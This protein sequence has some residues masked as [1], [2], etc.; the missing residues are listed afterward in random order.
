V[1]HGHD[2]GGYRRGVV[3][4]VGNARFWV[5][6]DGDGPAILFLHFGLGDW[7]VFEPQLRALAGSF[8]CVAYDR[9]GH[10][11]TESPEEPYAD[12]DDAVGLL[13]AL[14]IERAALV[15]LSG[16]GSIAL[17]IAASHPDRVW[18]LVHIAAPVAGIPWGLSPEHEAA[19]E[20]ADTPEAEEA[21]DY[22]VWAPLGVEDHF[23]E[24]RSQVR[25][26]GADRAPRPP[27]AL[28]EVEAPTLVIT[29]RLDPP[30][31]QASG[32][33]A[34][35]RIPTAQLVEVDSDHYLTLREPERV[36]KLIRDFLAPLA[37]QQ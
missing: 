5:E 13:D 12:V 9:R 2:A 36:T 22:A 32:R 14:G 24:L 11:R 8:R 31:L 7:R 28:E 6:Q 17:S 15:G 4:E 30:D 35:R 37:P 29:A 27:V 20:A 21:V 3:V 19:Y 23:R 25:E 33:E 16:G 26:G 34:A 1:F 18:A 10:G